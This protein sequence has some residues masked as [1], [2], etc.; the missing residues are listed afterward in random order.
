M[1]ILLD[2]QCWLWW[3]GT[4]SRLNQAAQKAIEDR[5]NQLFLSAASS[6]EIAI[7]W[8]L[9]KLR[10]PLPPSQFIPGRLLRGQTKAL[11]IEHMHALTV[12]SLPLH[13]KDPFDR[14]LIAQARIEKLR[15]LT[16]D[17]SFSL[18]EVEILWAGPP[19]VSR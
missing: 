19:A 15:I 11:A 3:H 4:P 1:R 13:H 7:K 12:A 9:G 2:T 5:R 16:A 14:L 17:P 18:Y 10:L 8:A 6:W